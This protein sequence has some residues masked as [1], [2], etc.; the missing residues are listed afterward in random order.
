MQWYTAKAADCQTITPN[1]EPAPVDKDFDKIRLAKLPEG[2]MPK[3]HLRRL[4]DG[5]YMSYMSLAGSRLKLGGRLGIVFVFWN[6]GCD[7]YFN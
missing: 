2:D 4:C 6:D 7:L 1:L 3:G 5:H